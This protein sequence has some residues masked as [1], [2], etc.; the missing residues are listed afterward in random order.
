MNAWGTKEQV[1]WTDR[2]TQTDGHTYKTDRHKDRDPDV[3]SRPR[4]FRHARL[5]FV[6]VSGVANRRPRA[7]APNTY[8]GMGGDVGGGQH[9]RRSA[10]CLSKRALLLLRR[11]RVYRRRR[12]RIIGAAA[13]KGLDDFSNGLL[14]SALS[15]QPYTVIIAL[16][17]LLL[18]FGGDCPTRIH[19]QGIYVM[20]T[21]YLYM[22]L[23]LYI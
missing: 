2:H 3:Y 1:T 13:E 11:R 4:V 9:H 14:P 12:G 16:E 22:Y 10:A 8:W 18:L 19:T 20:S 21:V 7:V 5:T 6:T 23:Y 15:K 17:G